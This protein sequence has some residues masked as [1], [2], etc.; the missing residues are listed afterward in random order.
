MRIDIPVRRNPG[1]MLLDVDCANGIYILR[2]KLLVIS[3]TSFGFLFFIFSPLLSHFSV[4][5]HLV[6]E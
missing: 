4:W 5:L 1:Y 6:L 3:N 2:R